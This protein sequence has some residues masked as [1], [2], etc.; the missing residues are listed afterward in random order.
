MNLN[1]WLTRAKEAFVGFELEPFFS[2]L[3]RVRDDEP[4]VRGVHGLRVDH[5]EDGGGERDDV[6]DQLE[7]DGQP[8][9]GDDRG[10]VADLREI[11][12]GT[13]KSKQDQKAFSTSALTWFSSTLDSLSPMNCFCSPK[14]LKIHSKHGR[15]YFIFLQLSLFQAYLIVDAPVTVS[16]KCE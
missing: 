1:Y 16:P 11:S 15:Q 6:A 14:A 12:L 8:A 5:D 2:Y 3:Q 9:V 10:V 4:H 13:V 7:A